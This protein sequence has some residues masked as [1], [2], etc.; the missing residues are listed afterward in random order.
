MPT[1]LQFVKAWELPFQVQISFLGFGSCCVQKKSKFLF[2]NES[3]V[4]IL[5]DCPFARRMWGNLNFKAL[6][7]HS[8]YKSWILSNAIDHSNFFH[9]VS[10]S[11][12]FVYGLCELWLNRNRFIF[13]GAHSLPASCGRNT[14]IKSVEFT[15]LAKDVLPLSSYGSV[16]VKWTAPS[17]GWW[18]L[19]TDGACAGNPSKMAAAGVIR[20]SYGNWIRGF[21]KCLGLGNS[22]KAEL[23]AIALG[24]S[25]A[26]DL[27]CDKLIIESDSLV[28]IKLITADY[29]Y[30]SLV[31]GALIHFCR[32]T[33]RD[34]MEVQ[35]N[36]IFREGNF[37]ADV[38]AKQAILDQQALVV[39][40][41][42]PGFVKACFFADL[43]GVCYVR[44][45]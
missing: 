12:V 6:N 24:M 5:R 19:N 10:R 2:V 22:L 41:T 32:L 37:C 14:Y 26:K 43:V 17:E 7:C 21:S 30:K 1:A 25:M 28:A 34:F 13:N 38:M 15:H 3:Q 39:F 27:S 31:L 44:T 11:T 20:D 40:N 29:D 16:W 23:W 45:S 35:I 9:N 18:K 4:H 8:D 33:V 36:H 42:V